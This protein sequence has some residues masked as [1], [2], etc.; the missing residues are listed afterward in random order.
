[1]KL[2]KLVIL[3]MFVSLFCLTFPAYSENVNH[4]TINHPAETKDAVLNNIFKMIPRL[5][6][7]D[8]KGLEGILEKNIIWKYEGVV[9]AVPFAGIYTGKEGVRKF[10]RSF[11][12]SVINP[13]AELRYYLHQ[14]NIV[15]LHWTEEGI[16]KSTGKKYLMETIQR[17]EF[18]EKGALVKLHWYNDTYALYEAFQ[19]NSNPQLSL[20]QHPAD[21]HINGNGPVDALPVVQ[22]YYN[23]YAQGNL[24]AI[25]NSVVPNFVLILAGPEGLTKIAG[26]WNGPQ[27]LVAFFNVVFTNEQYNAFYPISF[28][29]DGC[30]V[31]VEFVEQ[32]VIIETGKV[33]DC[34]GLH[35]FVVNSSGKM[36]KLRSYND[37]YSVAWGYT[38]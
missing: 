32:I 14:G 21:Y 17:W 38:N 3:V 1:M 24:A 29:T 4:I 5:H 11:F 9:G 23:E 34:T 6:H 33:V 28:T 25:I 20:A 8:G 22:N 18:N 13:K 30:R 31:D 19:P 36:A 2:R 27:E 15:H 16:I 12:N 7:L 37:T 10:W 35:S 26:T